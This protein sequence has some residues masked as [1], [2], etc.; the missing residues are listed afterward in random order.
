MRT[1]KVDLTSEKNVKLTAHARRLMEGGADPGDRLE[2]WRGDV[3][4]LIGV[5]G[6]LADSALAERDAGN[7]TFRWSKYRPMPSF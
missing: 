7:P 5:V 6:E 4:C 1:H 2:G 3:L